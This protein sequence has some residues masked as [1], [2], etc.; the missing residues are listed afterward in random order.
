MNQTKKRL[1]IVNLA[2]SMT[3]IETIQLQVLKLTMLKS[4]IK[5]GEI[6]S[7]LNA[8]NYAQAQ[9]LITEYIEAPNETVLQRTTQ[10]N[11]PNK[12]EKP[13]SIEEDK[14]II[15][16][17][18]LFTTPAYEASKNIQEEINYDAFLDITSVPEKNVNTEVDYKPLLN[19]EADNILSNNIDLDIS[20]NHNESLKSIQ[21]EPPL[22]KEITTKNTVK[23]DDA[24]SSN[25]TGKEDQTIEE[26]LIHTK[27]T[28]LNSEEYSCSFYEA[29]P[30]INN[31]FNNLY[32]QYPPI[33]YTDNLYES[34]KNWLLQVSTKG[35]TEEDIETHIKNVEELKHSNI[36]EAA[37]LLIAVSATDSLYA[38]FQLARALFIGN[39]LQKN[40]SEAVTLI[41]YLAINEEYPEAMCDLAQFYERGIEVKKDKKR[42][43]E[44]YKESM[45]LGIQRASK[46]YQR[47]Q[48]KHKSLL[49]I[50]KK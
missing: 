24:H 46:H 41:H 33:E 38:L 34:V 35:Y 49:D 7:A 8:Q 21:E 20:Q 9:G 40:I 39:I 29:I 10:D 48:K 26:N 45:H 2:I 42:A 3:D 32:T 31:K 16:E 23:T 30:H 44:L 15:E 47:I 37:Q 25:I 43:E 36:E 4:D 28:N 12:E 13:T 6:L 18:D 19:I 50:F 22:N 5:I 14:A 17:F 11:T 1:T 27:K